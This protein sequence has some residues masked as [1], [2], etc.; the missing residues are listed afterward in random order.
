VKIAYYIGKNNQL[1]KEA[2]EDGDD[3]PYD[4]MPYLKF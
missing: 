4:Y 2:V 1:F 3:D